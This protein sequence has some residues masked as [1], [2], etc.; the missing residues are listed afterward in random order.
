M[1]KI[2]KIFL[3]RLNPIYFL[4]VYA[5]HYM[6]VEAKKLAL[7][8]GFKDDQVFVLDMVIF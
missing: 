8:N 6:L 3:A 4:P 2:K 5:N 7:R 1:L